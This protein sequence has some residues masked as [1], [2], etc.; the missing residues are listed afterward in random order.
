MLAAAF[1]NGADPFNAFAVN[2]LDYLSEV[3][4]SFVITAAIAKFGYHP[5]YREFALQGFNAFSSCHVVLSPV[6]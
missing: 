2:A 4:E 5:N 6:C 1:K 3:V